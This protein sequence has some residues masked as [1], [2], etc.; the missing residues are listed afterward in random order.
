MAQEN[1]QAGGSRPGGRRMATR[2]GVVISS[3]MDKTVVVA[4]RRLV[5]HKTYKRVVR[6]TSKFYAHDERN[7]CKVGDYVTIV[8]S[9]PLSKL[10]RWRVRSI[11]REGQPLVEVKQLEVDPYAADTGIPARKRR[12]DKAG[13]PEEQEAS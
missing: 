3:K 4:V 8:E 1:T 7:R 5:Q 13:E 2:T 12:A 11:V 10:K 9:R 6:R